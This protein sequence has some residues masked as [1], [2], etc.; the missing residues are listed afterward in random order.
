MC[1]SVIKAP[2]PSV[3]VLNV[4]IYCLLPVTMLSVALLTTVW[5]Y[6][7][8]KPPYGHVDIAE[9]SLKHS[10]LLMKRV[11]VLGYFALQTGADDVSLTLQC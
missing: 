2:P 3:G 4:M 9:V 5:M 6:Q 7:H 1:V 8:R 10:Y 11:E